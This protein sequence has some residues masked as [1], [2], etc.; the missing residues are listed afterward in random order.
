MLIP[1]LNR[2][3]RLLI[4][5]LGPAIIS[6]FL[7]VVCYFVLAGKK[8][9]LSIEIFPI[10]IFGFF[11]SLFTALIFIGLQS[12]VYTITMEFIIRP[13][14]RNRFIYLFVSCMLGAATSWTIEYNS[15]FS[16]FGTI[17]GFLTGLILYDKEKAKCDKIV[18]HKL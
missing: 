17:I 14:I 9:G 12:L 13:K 18:G 10:M 7:I 8:D 5:L 15:Y 6:S 3:G 16:I 4:G 2:T 1:K 11:V